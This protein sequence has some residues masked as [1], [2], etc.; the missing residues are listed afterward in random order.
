MFFN[1][2]SS[3]KIQPYLLPFPDADSAVGPGDK[4]G[5]SQASPDS[6]HMKPGQPKPGQT[7]KLNK[8]VQVEN[9]VYS[10]PKE[11]IAE[12]LITPRTVEDE[13]GIISIKTLS[14]GSKQVFFKFDKLRNND[15]STPSLED[16]YENLRTTLLEKTNF[17]LLGKQSDYLTAIVRLLE[18]AYYGKQNVDERSQELFEEFSNELEILSPEEIEAN[19]NMG[20]DQSDFWRQ[21]RESQSDQSETEEDGNGIPINIQE[22]H[23]IGD[24]EIKVIKHNGMAVKIKTKVV[25]PVKETA[26]ILFEES[27]SYADERDFEETGKFTENKD[28]IKID[29]REK[30]NRN[31]PK[32]V[33]GVYED[34]VERSK[35]THIDK[36]DINFET[37][38]QNVN[39][40]L[41]EGLKNVLEK[42]QSYERKDIEHN[43]VKFQGK[44]D[45]P[46]DFDKPDVPK[47]VSKPVFERTVRNLKSSDS[48]NSIRDSDSGESSKTSDIESENIESTESSN[49]ESDKTSR[50]PGEL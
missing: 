47:F 15:L 33:S 25:K 3:I 23:N 46:K 20:I 35:D 38:E 27:H 49:Q 42:E 17:K 10:F 24:G 43:G 32:V 7:M 28:F 18:T 36:S 1:T 44:N 13:D 39:P 40:E 6:Q 45:I 19:K 31:E 5:Q 8:M 50:T 41:A 21:E 14:D 29:N 26:E 11:D 4:T 2:D 9:G 48:K 12:D 30:E 22:I 34:G 16:I 37:L